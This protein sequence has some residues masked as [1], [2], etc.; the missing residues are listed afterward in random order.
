M[1]TPFVCAMGTAH[2]GL[3][4]RPRQGRPPRARARVARDAARGL[5][6]RCR[7]VIG[8]HIAG[9]Y[10]VVRLLGEGGMGAVYEAR[11][12]G[13]GRR[14]ALKVITGALAWNPQVVA[15]FELEARAAGALESE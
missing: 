12:T 15:R 14:V 13:T 5:R 7:A 10:A 2:D 6:L 4:P 11:H 9:K 3:R 8:E 1:L